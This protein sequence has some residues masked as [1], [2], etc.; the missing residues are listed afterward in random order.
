MMVNQRE[1]DFRAFDHKM[2]GFTTLE[3]LA[4]TMLTFLFFGGLTSAWLMVSRTLL[5]WD[6]EWSIAA[7]THWAIMRIS[8]DLE[9]AHYIEVT[10]DAVLVSRTDGVDIYYRIGSHGVLRNDILMATHGARVTDLTIGK[11]E[12]PVEN[13]SFGDEIEITL[14]VTRNARSDVLR[15]WVDLHGLPHSISL[16]GDSWLR[17][18][19]LDSLFTCCHLGSRKAGLMHRS[20]SP[21]KRVPREQ[22]SA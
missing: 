12:M 2:S 16:P 10:S 14:T 8:T 13:L 22:L 21:L 15:R 1:V 9:S 5:K 7:T 4:A 3:L 6:V 20:L 19:H 17:S 18:I 11:R